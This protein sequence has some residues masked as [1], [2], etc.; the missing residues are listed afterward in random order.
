MPTSFLVTNFAYG[1]GPYLRTTEL[2]LALN[3]ELERRGEDRLGILVPW[4]YGEKQKGIMREEFAPYG[5]E[6]FLDGELG[7]ILG[8]VFYWGHTYEEALIRWSE[9]VK[10]VSQKANRH[11]SGERIEAVGLS[12]KPK[13]IDP[14][15]IVLELNRSPRVR[16]D[17]APSYFTTFSYIADI[18]GGVK[19]VPPD[20]VSV[21]KDLLDQGIEAAHWVE[22]DQTMHAVAYPATFSW[23]ADYRPRYQTE[24][25]TPPISRLY[26]PNGEDIEPGIFVTI[27][28]IPGLERLYADAKRLGLRIYSNVPNAVPGSIRMLPQVIPNRNI[29]F[30]F[31]RSGW[32]SVWL[33]MISGTPLVV[34]D[35]DP[36]D[37]PEVYFNNT[38]VEQLGIGV[39]YRGEP[40]ETVLAH[41]P[42]MKLASANMRDRILSRWGTLDGNQYCAKIFAEDFLKEKKSTAPLVRSIA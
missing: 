6:I 1:T 35:F 9:S 41:A 33:S 42:G 7:K 15:G 11:L 23:R 40:L 14:K 34:P 5:D 25:L 32:S 20:K 22:A 24:V 31:A 4:V 39:V 38:A 8:S 16:Y 18:L 13:T 10:N 28:G 17:I 3:D 36:K 21:R 2:A 37:D 26:A 27:T 12:G 30:Q 19:D 29:L